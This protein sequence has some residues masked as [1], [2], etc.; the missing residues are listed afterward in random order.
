MALD[1]IHRP[2]SAVF[3]C[4]QLSQSLPSTMTD[5]LVDL[6]VPVMRT[7]SG[8]VTLVEVGAGWPVGLLLVAAAE[9]S[10]CGGERATFTGAARRVGPVVVDVVRCWGARGVGDARWADGWVRCTGAGTCLFPRGAAGGRGR[11]GGTTG[12]VG[13]VGGA[14]GFCHVR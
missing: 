14:A 8:G 1:S 4:G 13:R 5:N 3:S 9:G 7:T 12:R 11:G 6:Y 2:A 10:E